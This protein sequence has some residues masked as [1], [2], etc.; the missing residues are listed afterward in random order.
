MC[1]MCHSELSEVKEHDAA[2]AKQALKA[3]DE[4]Y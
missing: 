2:V 1:R 4:V 3:Q